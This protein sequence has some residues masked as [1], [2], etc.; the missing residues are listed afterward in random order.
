MRLSEVRGGSEE[1]DGKKLRGALGGKRNLEPRGSPFSGNRL[2]ILFHRLQCGMLVF[3]CS[4]CTA[5]KYQTGF[6]S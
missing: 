6:L 2:P 5:V 3:K 1:L 4:S